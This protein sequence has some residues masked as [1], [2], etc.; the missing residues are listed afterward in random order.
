VLPSVYADWDR[1]ACEVDDGHTKYPLLNQ[2]R[3][4]RSR[5]H[6]LL[7]LTAA[8]D[9]A[10]ID[11]S[12]RRSPPAEARLFL[13][14]GV[15]CVKDLAGTLQLSESTI[16]DPLITK[17]E[18]EQAMATVA[19]SGFPCEVPVDQAWL[20]FVAWRKT[21]AVTASRIL[22]TVV[23]PDAPW[24]GIRSLPIRKTKHR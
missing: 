11:L 5:H 14:S 12:V 21:Y 24:T 13:W 8:M 4:P 20:S 6:W 9:A 15:A 7:S 18:F 2:F 1:W 16:E 23:A 22:D 17:E 3:L 10:A 19:G